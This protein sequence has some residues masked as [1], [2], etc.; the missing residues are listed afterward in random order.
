MLDTREFLLHA[1]LDAESLDAWIAAGWL[2]PRRERGARRFAEIDV[3]RAQLIHDLKGD[4]GINDEG[5]DV[6]LDLVDQIHGLRRTLR[7]LMSS[8]HAQPDAMRRRIIAE[9][10]LATGARGGDKELP[11]V[12]AEET[13]P[14]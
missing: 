10:R 14:K 3:A 7:E 8:I 5:V 6:I 4:L 2:L 9:L 11:S 12:K 1:R 13:E